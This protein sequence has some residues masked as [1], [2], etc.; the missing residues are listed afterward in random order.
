[1][2]TKT[3]P[4]LSSLASDDVR[5][6]RIEALWDDAVCVWDSRCEY[7]NDAFSKTET[8]RQVWIGRKS[9]DVLVDS[10]MHDAKLFVAFNADC[11][12]PCMYYIIATSWE[13]AYEVAQNEIAPKITEDE[14]PDYGENFS[15][16]ENGEPIDTEALQVFQVKLVRIDVE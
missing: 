14:L 10:T 12:S 2:S 15:V 16:N 6:V 4:S 5:V 1:M 9:T 13:D 7:S 3:L 11:F 8:R